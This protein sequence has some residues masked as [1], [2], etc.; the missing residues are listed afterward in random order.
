MREPFI[1]SNGIELRSNGR[2]W[3]ERR[4]GGKF[5][6]GVWGE[7]GAVITRDPALVWDALREFFQHERD[8]ELGRWR[9][10][11][12]TRYVVYEIDSD[13]LRVLY[14][15][16]GVSVVVRLSNLSDAAP[17]KNFVGAANAYRAAHQPPKPWHDAKPGEVWAVTWD[18]R[19]TP[20]LVV[21]SAIS[22]NGLV[23][24]DTSRET[25]GVLAPC[26]TNARRIWPEVVS[27]DS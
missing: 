26:I 5:G 15:P 24:N 21:E 4:N 3:L 19:E 11:K 13:Q 16:S 27:D 18:G 7:V 25:P 12:D 10:P 2:G 17:G 1:A 6:T 8:E 14:E 20:C 9:W 22:S 23:F